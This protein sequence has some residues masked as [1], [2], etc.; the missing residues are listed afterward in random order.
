VEAWTEIGKAS[1]QNDGAVGGSS[2]GGLQPSARSSHGRKRGR[3]GEERDCA[4]RKRTS[5]GRCSALRAGAPWRA[6]AGELGTD[7]N[8]D[9]Q[10]WRTQITGKRT[11][12]RNA[13]SWGRETSRAQELEPEQ[14]E[15]GAVQWSSGHG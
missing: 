11:P 13:A 8:M 10:G 14:R 3:L 2:T 6:G 5:A 12:S 4:R 15:L 7:A 9:E 1:A